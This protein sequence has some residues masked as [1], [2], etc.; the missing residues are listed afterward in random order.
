VAGLWAL[1]KFK[2]IADHTTVILVLTNHR[3]LFLHAVSGCDT[4][5]A[6]CRV[7][8]NTNWDV[9][10]SLSHL[11]KV[12]KCLS[13]APLEITDEDMD[14]LQRFVVILYSWTS[15][16]SHGEVNEAHKQLF[17]HGNRKVENISPTKEA[18]LQHVKRAVYQAGHIWCLVLITNPELP[19]ADWGWVKDE[20]EGDWCPFWSTMPEASKGCEGLIKCSCKSRC[21]GRCKCSTAIL[22][23]T[24]LCFCKGQCFRDQ[25]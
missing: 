3:L 23:C 8:K 5:S 18:L 4:V 22:Q 20:E 21:I 1:I 13:Q 7:G 14:H 2:Y 12:F 9:W 24:Q 11:G 17:A 16:L 6:F 10:K 15:S 19:S 25:E